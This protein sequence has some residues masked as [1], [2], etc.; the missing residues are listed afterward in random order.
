MDTQANQPKK[1]FSYWSLL[2]SVLLILGAT[3]VAIFVAVNVLAFGFAALVLGAI[4][5]LA[6]E[7]D[8]GYRRHRR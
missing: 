6:K 7:E 8:R 2:W 1:P 4:G 5:T 3:A